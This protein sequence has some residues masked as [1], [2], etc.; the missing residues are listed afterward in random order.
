MRIFPILGLILAFASQLMGQG[1]YKPIVPFLQKY[2]VECHGSD[3]Q[4]GDVRLDD[5][6]DIGADL[7]IEI[8]EQMEFGDMP[9]EEADIHPTKEHT[10]EILKLV[11]AISRD[12]RFTIAT[13]FRR[14][15][16][17]EYT[18]TVRDLLGLSDKLFNPGTYIFDDEVEK[19]FDTNSESLY[20]SNEL[21]L[22]YLNS[23]S[24]SL[25][26][27]LYT[28]DYTKPESNTDSYGPKNIEVTAYLDGKTP[29]YVISR[30]KKGMV[31][32]K[33]IANKVKTSGYYRIAATAA[34][35]DRSQGEYGGAPA[36]GR[37]FQM[38]IG[39]FYNGVSHIY[40]EFDIKDQKLMNYEGVVWL[41]KGALPY[42]QFINGT[43]KPRNINRMR[44]RRNLK[45]ITP[46][47]LAVGKFTM[48]GPL[49]LEWPPRTY[50]TAFQVNEMPDLELRG[51]RDQ[52]LR[53]FIS[54]AFRRQVNNE[55]RI[56]YTRYLEDQYSES[57]SWHQ[58]FIRTF[59][60]IMAS[61]DFLYI[62]EDVGELNPFQLANRLSY[63][64][65]SSMPDMELFK[66]ANSGELLDPEVYKDQ[67]RRMLKDPKSRNFVEGFALQWLSIDELGT[68]RPAEDDKQHAIYFRNNLEQA[69]R[70]ETLSFF[71]HILF[72]NQPITDFL[73]SDYT[74]LNKALADLYEIPFDGGNELVMVNLPRDS[75]RGGLL[76]QASIHAITSNG[77]E[78]LPVT[79]GHWVLD[80]LMGTPPPPPPEEVPAI[81]P[82]LNNVNTPRDLLVKHR[83]DPKCFACHKNMDPPGLALESFD[84]IGRYRD[85]YGKNS[86]ID[87]SGVFLGT[88]FDDIRGF[89]KALLK[90]KDIFAYNFIVKIAEYG[91]GR[92]L[93]RK[94]HEIVKELAANAKA[95]NYKFMYLLGDVLLSD[96]MKNR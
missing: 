77:V 85:S 13:G 68:M 3:K 49:K 62:K 9:P 69:M 2:C 12:E 23:A 96:L 89:K 24:F 48:E 92:K 64:L 7:W 40:H 55:E 4:K 28:E 90:D 27:A 30:V 52:I 80:E 63:L 51:M 87:P 26:A 78:T 86:T 70:S 39:V 10:A 8:Y 18:N 16:K 95:H 71:E 94:D 73:D 59:A 1:E 65:W 57:N 83:E 14:M 33:D 50:K 44:V 74:F 67:L 84:I 38:G 36:D 93:N 76:G 46:P 43:K 37:P 6:A 34:G 66:L 20:I 32:G 56:R 47:G 15:N 58:A 53:N 5:V 60:A 17:R 79:R 29:D 31:F 19:G 54:R 81:V 35:V 21:L 42:V 45:P 22:E 25:N 61:T 88:K 41:E 75:V 82:D 91:K 72:T 11:D